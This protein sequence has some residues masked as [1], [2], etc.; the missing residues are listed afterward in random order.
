MGHHETGTQI[1]N[2]ENQLDS[3]FAYC[4]RNGIRVEKNRIRERWYF[5]ILNE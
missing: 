5:K 2:Y 3:A 4:N 1:D